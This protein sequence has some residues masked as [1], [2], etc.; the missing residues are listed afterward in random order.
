MSS[1]ARN[2]R[3]ARPPK[4]AVVPRLFAAVLIAAFGFVQFSA[5]WH[6]ASV[7]HVRCAEHGEAIDVGIVSDLGPSPARHR[8]TSTGLEGTDSTDTTLH[9]HCS[10]VL[11]FRGSARARL[12]K[13]AIRFAP[14]PVVVR[15]TGEPARRPGRAFVLASAPKTSP[16]AA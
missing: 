12:V 15:R 5:S 11:V 3:P 16:P 2:L 8:A 10:V 4:G 9:E 6:E 7:R 1:T 13:Q 14:P